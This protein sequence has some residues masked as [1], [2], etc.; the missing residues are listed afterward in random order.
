MGMIERKV[1]TDDEIR[2]IAIKTQKS[3]LLPPEITPEKAF[4]IAMAGRDL[5][6]A[7][8]VAL[9]DIYV[10]K[11][12]PSLKAERCL[13]LAIER[14]P[15]FSH[16]ILECDAKK[17]TVKMVKRGSDPFQYTYTIEDAR[18]QGIVKNG[19]PWGTIPSLMLF[20]RC[21]SMMLKM[22]CPNYINQVD[23]NIDDYSPQ[24]SDINSFDVEHENTQIIDMERPENTNEI[25]V[26]KELLISKLLDDSDEV[27]A[28]KISKKLSELSDGYVTSIQ[29]LDGLNERWIQKLIENIDKNK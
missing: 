1:Y 19:P 4:V 6:L 20:Y 23:I 21:V 15:G 27:D 25:T 12:R 8:T 24:D 3:G 22:Y 17:C 10:I 7:P 14:I 5:G 2:D 13:A 29:Q 9:K 11:G 28:E 16:S 26:K 18:Q